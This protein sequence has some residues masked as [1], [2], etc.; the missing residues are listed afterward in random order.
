MLE[1]AFVLRDLGGLIRLFD[2]DAV[3]RTASDEARGPAQIDLLIQNLWAQKLTYLANPAAVL[4]VRGTALIVSDQAF[5]VA[6][7]NPDGHWRYLVVFLDYQ[8]RARQAGRLGRSVP[9]VV[10]APWP[11]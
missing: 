7:R 11:G 8:P 4:Q 5:N 1:D 2:H 9:R 6:R 10:S 3:L